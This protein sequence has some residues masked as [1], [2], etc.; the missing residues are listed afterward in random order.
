MY[1]LHEPTEGNFIM[2]VFFKNDTFNDP[3]R[4]PHTP[5]SIAGVREDGY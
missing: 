5:L 1:E 4:Q 2:K 3:T